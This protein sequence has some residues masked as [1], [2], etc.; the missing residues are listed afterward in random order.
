M[1]E[2]L[3]DVQ[4]RIYQF[5]EECIQREQRPPT[6]RE[7][8]LAVSIA[9][10]GH[11]DY[12]L[13]MLQ[14]KGY[15]E[16]DKATSRG[17]RLLK[18]KTG[19]PIRGTIAAGQPL[20]ILDTIDYETLDLSSSFS[21][22]DAYVLRV[23]GDSMIEDCIFDGDYVVIEPGRHINDGDIVVA[24]HREAESERGAATLKRFYKQGQRVRLQPAN[25]AMEPI[26]VD[27]DRWDKEWEVQGK[28]KA[29]IRR[30]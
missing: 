19:L 5:I 11:V 2:S 29:V 23:K 26:Y 28:V 20:N 14:R 10:T 9:S 27:G 15:I 7:I 25:S 12:H 1:A 4:K 8:G 21:G 17:I 6:N 18:T 13:S 30:F 16:R 3:S 24:T 22:R